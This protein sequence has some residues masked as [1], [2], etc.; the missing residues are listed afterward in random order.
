M[1]YKDFAA[2]IAGKKDLVEVVYV[3]KQVRCVK[4]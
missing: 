4:G 2:V 3:V 1:A